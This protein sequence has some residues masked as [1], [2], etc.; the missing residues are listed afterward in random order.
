MVFLCSQYEKVINV[1]SSPLLKTWVLPLQWR[2]WELTKVSSFGSKKVFQGTFPAGAKGQWE[3]EGPVALRSSLKACSGW[4]A[5]KACM[6]EE[7]QAAQL[8][9]GPLGVIL[10]HNIDPAK[11][12]QGWLPVG[13]APPGCACKVYIS[14][15][16]CV[17]LISNQHMLALRLSGR[18]GAVSPLEHSENA[19][20]A[21]LLCDSAVFCRMH[22]PRMVWYSQQSVSITHNCVSCFLCLNLR[23]ICCVAQDEL[24]D[25]TKSWLHIC[26]VKSIDV[27]R[28]KCKVLPK[29]WRL[30]VIASFSDYSVDGQILWTILCKDQSW[31]MVQQVV[32]WSQWP[33]DQE[34]MSNT[35]RL[36]LLNNTNTPVMYQVLPE[37]F[38]S[39]MR[40]SVLYLSSCI[41]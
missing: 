10:D 5:W 1:L 35:L 20:M 2:S 36:G 25:D 17:I 27:N 8:S 37:G 40:P 38:S 13:R 29:K 3:C 23:R 18:R 14:E 26:P 15:K 24:L 6:D 32:I 19:K 28:R 11:I 30:Q 9:G 34:D 39:Q 4:R 33:A 16:S 41:L 12:V 22:I 7:L 31:N 21:S